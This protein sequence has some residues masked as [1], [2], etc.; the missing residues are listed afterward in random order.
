MRTSECDSRHEEIPET[1]APKV[2]AVW[3]HFLEALYPT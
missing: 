3:V 2:Y 1:G